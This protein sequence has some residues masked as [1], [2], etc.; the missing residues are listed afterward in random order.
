MA[1]RRTLDRRLRG[2]GMR[3]LA[4]ADRMSASCAA[5]WPC[6]PGSDGPGAPGGA[7]IV[8]NQ[9]QRARARPVSA[10]FRRCAFA[11]RAR[12]SALGHVLPRYGIA[13][14]ADIGSA[15][16]ARCR[17]VSR[18]R[19][20]TSSGAPSCGEAAGRLRSPWSA[21][22]A[23]ARPGELCAAAWMVC[24]RYTQGDAHLAA[25]GRGVS[26]LRAAAASIPPRLPLRWSEPHSGWQS[27]HGWQSWQ[28]ATAP[29]RRP[30]RR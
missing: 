15:C 19:S 9:Q 17:H 7:S 26:P 23:C 10:R 25:M 24:L 21:R 6:V 13:A 28:P 27:A 14:S 16:A 29:A 5:A 11:F 18:H 3:Q 20:V 4:V 30:V 12:K 1:A 2:A 22:Q 8:V